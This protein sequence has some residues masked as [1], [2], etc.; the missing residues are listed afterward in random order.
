MDDI[1]CVTIG[2]GGVGKTCLLLT[3]GGQGFPES[4]VPTV[5]D[6]YSVRVPVDG[7]YITVSLWDTA[8][9][10]DYDR[11]RVLCYPASDVFIVAFSVVSPTSFLN[12]KTKWIPELKQHCAHV[13]F[14]LVGTKTDLRQDPTVLQQLAR[15]HSKPITFEQGV[16]LAREL[17]AAQYLECCALRNEGVKEVVDA[18]ITAVILRRKKPSYTFKQQVKKY[19]SR[20]RLL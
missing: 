7:K 5:C 11:L 14:V 4:Y 17:N 20:C 1:K 8:G 2:D 19:I 10:E 12:V 3:Y 6:N 9:Q 15:D 13:P 16:H 18:A